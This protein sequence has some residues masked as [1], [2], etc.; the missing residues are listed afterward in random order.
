[1]TQSV[2]MNVYVPYCTGIIFTND[3]L[4]NAM[5]CDRSFC[6]CV[7]AHSNAN[8]SRCVYIHKTRNTNHAEDL[9]P[10]NNRLSAAPSIEI[11]FGWQTNSSH[12]VGIA[13]SS[14][15]LTD[16]STAKPVFHDAQR[17]AIP[18][19]VVRRGRTVLRSRNH[20]NYRPTSSSTSARYR[21]TFRWFQVVGFRCSAVLVAMFAASGFVVLSACGMCP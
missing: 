5:T 11:C 12:I 10:A 19:G 1:M 7:S 20:T 2:D 21:G 16:I 6:V 14:Q 3:T 13:Q 17:V 9:Q 8:V 15:S 18:N 4:E